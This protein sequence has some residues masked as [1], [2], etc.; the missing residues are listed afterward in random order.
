MTERVYESLSALMDDE[1]DELELRRVL[2]QVRDDPELLARWERYHLVSAV[3]RRNAVPAPPGLRVELP[4]AEAPTLVEAPAAADGVPRRSGARAGSFRAGAGFAT[5]AGVTLAV[6]LAVQGP[7]SGAPE[8]ARVAELGPAVP[9]A[10][11][12]VSGPDGVPL[13][14]ISP[15][16][17]GYPVTNLGAPLQVS[18][19]TFTPPLADVGTGVV[20]EADRLRLLDEHLDAYMLHHAEQTALSQDATVLPFVKVASFAAE[21]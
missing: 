16:M 6:L 3:L 5:A 19:T 13:R 20:D 9:A 8:G 11:E 15:I 7:G 18:P 1:A 14:S 4:E 10:P 17:A 12:S 21:R 2:R